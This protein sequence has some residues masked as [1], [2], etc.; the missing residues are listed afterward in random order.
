MLVERIT[1]DFEELVDSVNHV[2]EELDPSYS[3]H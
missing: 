3:Q 2:L 1:P